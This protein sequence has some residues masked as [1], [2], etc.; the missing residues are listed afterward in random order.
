MAKI[1]KHGRFWREE[2]KQAYPDVN[3][4]CPEC[5]ELIVMSSYDLYIT[6]PVPELWCKCGCKFIPDMSDLVRERK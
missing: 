6:T 1:I 3:I 5:G 4:K 2:R